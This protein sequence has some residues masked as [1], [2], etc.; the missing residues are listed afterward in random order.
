MTDNDKIFKPQDDEDALE[1][2]RRI[3]DMEPNREPLRIVEQLVEIAVCELKGRP[4][5]ISA[6]VSDKRMKVTMRHSGKP[7]D[8]RMV[9]LMGDHTDCVDYHPEDDGTWEL[10]IRRDIPPLYVTRR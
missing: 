3:I 6:A 1:F 7:I 9:W 2:V 4:C 10:T 5:D 8:D